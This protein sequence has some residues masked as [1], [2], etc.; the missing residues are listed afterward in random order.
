MK[1][2]EEPCSFTFSYSKS[3]YITGETSLYKTEQESSLEVWRIKD[4]FLL[5]FFP[6]FKT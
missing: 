6:H 5:L 4:L 3:M 1:G 2:L